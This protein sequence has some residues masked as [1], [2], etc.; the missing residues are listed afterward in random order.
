MPAV[1]GILFD[2]D[3][4]LVDSA[5]QLTA[6]VNVL[7]VKLGLPPL[8]Y[9]AIRN[10]AGAGVRGLLWRALRI[11]PDAPHFASLKKA[12][13]IDYEARLTTPA[14]LF[15]GIETLLTRLTE[16]NVPWGIV[17]NKPERLAQL[18]VASHPMPRGGRHH[19]GNETLPAPRS[20][21]GKAPSAHAAENTLRRGRRTRHPRR[22]SRGTQNSGAH[23]GVY[24]GRTATSLGLGSRLLNNVGRRNR[25]A[26]FLTPQSRRRLFRKKT[27]EPHRPPRAFRGRQRPQRRNRHGTSHRSGAQGGTGRRQ[28]R[29]RRDARESL[30]RV[31]TTSF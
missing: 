7:R 20:R 10:A 23:L 26:L 13:L 15:P 28:R 14:V 25:G 16:N 6:S 17:T 22:P 9:P 1:D 4:T 27:G 12:F 11:T 19:T 8:V 30:P 24:C 31:T 5:P 21:R 18:V 3:G 2:L 29:L